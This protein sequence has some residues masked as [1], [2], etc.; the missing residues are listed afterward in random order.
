MRVVRKKSGSRTISPHTNQYTAAVWHEPECDSG[1]KGSNTVYLDFWND[2]YR[3][4]AEI[5]RNGHSHLHGRVAPQT[6]SGA[7]STAHDVVQF[8]VGT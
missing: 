4:G 2:L 6:P 1:P 5:V 8:T 3:A 7:L